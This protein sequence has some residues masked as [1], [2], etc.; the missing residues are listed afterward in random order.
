VRSPESGL[1]VAYS[2]LSTMRLRRTAAVLLATAA[3]GC[4]FT[5][6]VDNTFYQP[7]A[8]PHAAVK[9]L[10]VALIADQAFS[11]KPVLITRVSQGVSSN[12]RSQIELQ[13]ALTEAIKTMMAQNFESVVV[14]NSPVDAPEVAL[15]AYPE[16]PEFSIDDQGE[17][18]GTLG[19]TFKE[20][21]TGH[22]VGGFQHKASR[23]EEGSSN[24]NLALAATVLSVGL[25]YPTFAAAGSTD[26]D[27]RKNDVAQIL[28][29]DLNGISNEIQ[30]SSAFNSEIR[31]LG[32]VIVARP[33]ALPATEMA[34]GSVPAQIAAPATTPTAPTSQ[35][36]GPRIALVIG[37][38]RYQNVPGLRNPTNDARLMA[39][40]LQAFGFSLVDGGAQLDLDK[41]AFDH[42]VQDFGDRLHGS[43]V[44][45]FYYAGHGIQARGDNYLV[46][47]SAN[48]TKES[49]VDFQM[50][51]AQSILHE[52]Q[53]G[54]ARLNILI[55]DACRNNPF[56]GR[57]LRAVNGGLAQMQAPEGALISYATQPGN[58]ASDGDGKDSPYTEALTDAMS[59]PTSDL[60]GVFNEV[61][62]V[63][64]RR[65]GGNQ[66]PWISTSPIDGDF[67]FS[68]GTEGA[69]PAMPIK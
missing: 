13:P 52:M 17:L 41:A 64:K 26:A 8:A 11:G 66:Q 40:T 28:A 56:G 18:Q 48:P 34:T 21:R 39:A 49:D 57:G 3:V 12:T 47:I 54:G 59:N 9:P 25:L 30:S 16:I 36:Q 67:Y 35:I 33:Q 19:L 62:L 15:Y 61:G 32:G 63:V 31:S 51:S 46:P 44:A 6:S 69:R 7:S 24:E 60:F 53:D 65:T 20:A 4:T 10:K 43:A 27:R 50:V 42:A 29:E 2:L 14:V 38:S 37:N 45:L 23:V 5:S 55:L 1:D 58:V 22:V 68:A